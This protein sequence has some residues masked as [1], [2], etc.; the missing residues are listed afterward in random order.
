LPSIALDSV[1]F[2]GWVFLFPDA[3]QW[4]WLRWAF[5]VIFIDTVGCHIHGWWDT[6][7]KIEI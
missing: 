6:I 7:L 5:V 4:K 2:S 3:Q 1:L